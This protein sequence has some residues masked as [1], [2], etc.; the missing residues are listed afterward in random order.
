MMKIPNIWENKNG[1]NHQP[2]EHGIKSI[3]VEHRALWM[4]HDENL[5]LKREKDLI[6]PVL[7]PDMS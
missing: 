3:F 5:H 1:P 7:S 4:K 2:V 6:L